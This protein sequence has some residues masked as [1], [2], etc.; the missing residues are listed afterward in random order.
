MVVCEQ[1]NHYKLTLIDS[2]GLIK[3]TM[4]KAGN[5]TEVLSSVKQHWEQPSGWYVKLESGNRCLF[6]DRRKP[7]ISEAKLASLLQ[8][9]L[10]EKVLK[11]LQKF[12]VQHKDLFLNELLNLN[13]HGGYRTCVRRL[14]QFNEKVQQI[15]AVQVLMDECI[16]GMS[17]KERFSLQTNKQEI[18]EKI[19]LSSKVY[20]NMSA[21]E[22][23]SDLDEGYAALGLWYSYPKDCGELSTLF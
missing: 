23:P 10:L 9:M 11:H 6:E 5:D 15:H 21:L 19:K 8:Y 3:Q 1:I 14:D 12:E 13:F 7:E 16:A 22:N 20:K 2:N 17:E 18:E 4:I